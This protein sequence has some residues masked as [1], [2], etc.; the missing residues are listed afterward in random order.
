MISA[1]WFCC[2]EVNIPRPLSWKSF[3]ELLPGQAAGKQHW[4]CFGWKQ[5]AIWTS[6]KWS[7]GRGRQSF[8][9]PRT[10]KTPSWGVFDVSSSRNLDQLHTPSSSISFRAI[11]CLGQ[12]CRDGPFLGIVPQFCKWVPDPCDC[13]NAAKWS[14]PDW[15]WSGPSLLPCRQPA[16]GNAPPHL[17]RGWWEMSTSA[18]NTSQNGTGKGTTRNFLFLLLQSW[19]WSWKFVLV[20]W[21]FPIPD[22]G[23]EFHIDT[24]I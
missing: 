22:Y 1:P 20:F 6:K 23:Q 15:F 24:A 4:V 2:T 13:C 11:L 10:C 18:K 7:L 16:R 8:T 17:C 21:F 3:P 5:L 9:F 12:I 14:L 19:G